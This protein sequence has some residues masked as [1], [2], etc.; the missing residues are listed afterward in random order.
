MKP[1]VFHEDAEAE[2]QAAAQWYEGRVPGWGG[3][4][5]AE[6]EAAASPEAFGVLSGDIRCHLLERFPYGLLYR[7]ESDRILILVV[8]HLHREPGY[9]EDRR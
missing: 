2:L 8:M 7:I 4:F 1:A 5:R 9:W 6:A 3:S